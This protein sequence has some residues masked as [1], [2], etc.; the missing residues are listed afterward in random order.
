MGVRE[1]WDMECPSCHDDNHLHITFTGECHLTVDG[2][3]DDGDHEWNDDSPCRCSSCDWSG[4]VG[5]C[6][7]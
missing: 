6:S 1:E 5:D 2:T 3:D 4:K 7:V